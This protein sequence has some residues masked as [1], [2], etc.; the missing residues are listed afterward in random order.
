MSSKAQYQSVL[1][2]MNVLED[3]FDLSVALISSLDDGSEVYPHTSGIYTQIANIKSWSSAKINEIE[4]QEMLEG[5]LN[6]MRGL[7]IEYGAKL[8]IVSAAEGVGYGNSFGESYGGAEGSEVGFKL[9]IEKEGLTSEKIY[10]TLILQ[11]SN[12]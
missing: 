5:F 2:D 9:T 4:K 7:F 6:G 1:D 12:I 3:Q 11:G 10:E 8:E